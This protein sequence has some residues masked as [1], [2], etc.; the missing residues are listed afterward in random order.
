MVLNELLLLPYQY[1]EQPYL[2]LALLPVAAFI[3]WFCRRNF[4]H[5]KLDED[6]IRRRRTAAKF[7]TVSR[8]LI[9]LLLLIALA[10]PFIIHEKSFTGDPLIKI[11]VDN[12]SSMNVFS[13]DLQK[14]EQ[15]LKNKVNVEVK[16]FGSET[17]SNL[18]DAVLQGMESEGSLLV[19]SDGV[20]TSGTTLSDAA[21]VATKFN[22]S[23]NA[24]RLEAVKNDVAVQILGPSK[25]LEDTDNTFIVTLGRLGDKATH[26][27]LK[28]D[29]EVII[30][31][32]TNDKS[33]SVTRKLSK[34]SHRF[35]ASTSSDFF[36]QNNMF[37]KS[38]KAVPKPR[39]FLWAQKETPIAQLYKQVYEVDAGQAL[40]QNLN[41]YYALVID[42]IPAASL[43]EKI[44]QLTE[45]VVDGNGLFVVGGKNSFDNGNYKN[46]VIETILPVFVSSAEKKEG[47]VNVVLVADISGS[48]GAAVGLGTAVALG[49]SLIVSVL[50]DLAPENHVGMTAFNQDAYTI[51]PLLP[52]VQQ[53]DLE[54][55]IAR[56]R[57][58]G[59]TQVFAGLARAVV[60]LQ[61]TS[62][63]KNIIVL[64]D[65]QSQSEETDIT[66]A[67]AAA[68]EG[69]KIYPIG[70]GDTNDPLLQQ[71]ASITGGVYFKATEASRIKILFGNLDEEKKLAEKSLLVL[72]K[73]HFITADLNPKAKIYGFNQVLAKTGARLLMTTSS[74]E[75][76][77]AV[78]R[79]GLGRV[80]VLATDDGSAWAGQ[81]LGAPES[82][83]HVKTIHW[84]VGDPER[85][86]A[87]FIDIADARVHEPTQVVVRSP[88]AYPAAL[89]Y[90]FY[91]TDKDLYT[92]SLI[93]NSTGF[94]KL[95]SGEFAVNY[96]REYDELGQSKDLASIVQS[97]GGKM[98]GIDEV[99]AIVDH[100]KQRLKR[101][102]TTKEPFRL[103]FLLA[104]MIIFLLEIFVRRLLRTE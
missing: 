99:D 25:V 12:S 63:S 91:K 41:N 14:L 23:I 50:R 8:I 3:I 17:T 51:A 71:L 103:P 2:L 101:T 58:G 52:M 78:W 49:K 35:E 57:E 53:T 26:V 96:D 94:Q 100:T 16:T 80:G 70:V 62:G 1:L 90:T 22:T 10:T 56:L 93:P 40:P 42:D 44:G 18:G 89:G 32:D 46:S 47:R 87:D 79:L 7:M 84:A 31:K 72:D 54:D 102:V 86:A 45:F 9:A 13:Y 29:N 69:I 68:N 76:A 27:Q 75:P 55:R 6:T 21:R 30:E 39:V 83:V 92:A 4:S 97:T 11:L 38:V 36:A 67:Q 81:L 43:T 33:I 85:K 65:G 88:G 61:Q 77:L 24:I 73:N 104:A 15:A 98:F 5:V 20:V 74:G 48:M 34:G 64:T 28:L 60:M 59:G 19:V 82:K 66:T 95:L 37:Y